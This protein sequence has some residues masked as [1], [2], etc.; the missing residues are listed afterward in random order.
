[1]PREGKRPNANGG[2]LRKETGEAYGKALATCLRMAR[3]IS[4]QAAGMP[5]RDKELVDHLIEMAYFHDRM[6]EEVFKITG[7]RFYVPD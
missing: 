4:R 1:M 7:K 5:R 3:D 2:F 6:E